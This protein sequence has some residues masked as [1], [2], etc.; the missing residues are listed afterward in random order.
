MIKKLN[1]PR[2]SLYS[3]YEID[4]DRKSLLRF[5]QIKP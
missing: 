5:N 3:G 4:I 2:K 1:E